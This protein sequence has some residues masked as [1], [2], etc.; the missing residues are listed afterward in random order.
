MGSADV[1]PV[2]DEMALHELRGGNAIRFIARGRSMWPFILD[3]DSVTVSP[4]NSRPA[5]GDVIFMPNQDF[6]QLHRIVARSVDGR[7]CVQGD[8]LPRPD[9]WIDASDILGI[10]TEQR[11][12]GRPVRVK[13]GTRVVKI[14]RTL[15]ICRRRVHRIRSFFG[16]R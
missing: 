12:N 14:A 16:F 10:L 1:R 7:L 13:T 2:V 11:R 9:G 6:G 8:A 15:A 4:L 3:G 5:L